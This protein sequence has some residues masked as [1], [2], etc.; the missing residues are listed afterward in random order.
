MVADLL[1]DIINQ[2]KTPNVEGK[3][4]I[5]FNEINNFLKDKKPEDIEEIAKNINES[6]DDLA[7]TLKDTI[8]RFYDDNR[9]H[10]TELDENEM[11][12]LSLWKELWIKLDLKFKVLD[13]LKLSDEKKKL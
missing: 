12:I 11:K 8:Q 6:K 7:L 1:N 5:D 10:L 13:A 2:D 9:A 3:Q 4:E